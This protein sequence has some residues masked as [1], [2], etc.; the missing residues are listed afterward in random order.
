MPSVSLQKLILKGCGGCLKDL[1]EIVHINSNS[2]GVYFTQYQSAVFMF[3]NIKV[4]SMDEVQI[5]QYYGFAIPAINPL[6]AFIKGIIICLST[7]KEDIGSGIL[8]LF[9]DSSEHLKQ[10]EPSIYPINVTVQ[11]TIMYNNTANI[12]KPFCLSY[13][14]ESNTGPL[15]I[16]HGSG[17]TVYYT[18]QQFTVNLLVN[19]LFMQ[20]VG[21]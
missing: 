5:V 15:P 3:L 2:S 11:D 6:S 8:L 21:P 7:T 10:L 16:V 20:T 1:D 14:K 12:S 17:I 18:Q 19:G 4:L 9:T 13:L